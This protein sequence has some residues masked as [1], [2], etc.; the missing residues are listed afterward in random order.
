MDKAKFKK[1]SAKLKTEI[2]HYGYEKSVK[3]AEF[4]HAKE[5]FKTPSFLERYNKNSRRDI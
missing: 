1:S 4:L 2:M 3:D 5:K